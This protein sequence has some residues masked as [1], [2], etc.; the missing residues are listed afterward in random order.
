MS[1]SII[2]GYEET[3]KIKIL[4]EIIRLFILNKKNAL[5]HKNIENY[6]CKIDVFENKI[7]KISDHIFEINRNNNFYYDNSFDLIKIDILNIKNQFIELLKLLNI[8][9]FYIKNNSN[10]FFIRY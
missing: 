7:F 10:L 2:L 6:I 9:I 1:G 3:C 8:N 5:L 4:D